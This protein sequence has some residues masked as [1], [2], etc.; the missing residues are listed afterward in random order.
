MRKPRGATP[1]NE[2]RLLAAAL[3]VIILFWLAVSY[4]HGVLSPEGRG[5]LNDLLHPEP[6]TLALRIMIAALIGL[7]AWYTQTMFDRYAATV[8][9]LEHERSKL[10]MV[11]DHSPDAVIILDPDYTVRY[12]N[13][14][15]Q[16][17]TR[18]DPE[19]L[20]GRRCFEAVLGLDGPCEGCRLDEVV[21]THAPQTGV[22]HS[23]DSTRGEIWIE[24]TF[25]PVLSQDGSIESVVE[26]ARD[27]T[28][29]RRAEVALQEYSE[30]LERE[31]HERTADI[32]RANELLTEEVAVR[33][34]AERAL[35]ESEERFR[36]LV[37]M[38]PDLILVHIEGVVSF[39]NPNGARMLGY[40]DPR[41]VLGTHV[42]EF[43]DPAFRDR[44]AEAL[45]TTVVERRPLLPTEFR[46]LRK[47]GTTVDV[48][49]SSTPLMYHGR[50]AVQAVAHD[51]TERKR[52]EET[53]RKMAYYDL[54][55][56]LP[57]R[58][59]F[60]DR[61]AV[62]IARAEREDSCFA[63]MFMDINDF[64]LINDSLGHA[65][66]DALLAE[67]G[68][69]LSKVVRRSDTVARLGGDEFTVL[70]P[71]VTSRKAAGLIAR[72]IVKALEEPMLIE[73]GAVPID[74]S[75]GI[76]FYPTDGRSFS[77]LMHAADMAMYASKNEDV[78]F[79]FADPSLVMPGKDASRA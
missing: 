72:K 3:G 58:A 36:S 13:P 49:V 59:L 5:F 17:L 42:L 38:A 8:R 76:A 15:T 45:R 62:A 40:D 2:P 20:V 53:I 48:Q 79:A 73:E 54:L 35:R 61:L 75:I 46:F 56:G 74:V 28:D 19:D 25:Y 33:R 10:Q 31:V 7:G 70:L 47:D 51:I 39:I 44:A 27:I 14:A 68:R 18:L 66:G 50:P 1:R 12:A 26:T 71:Q 32:E 55:T 16:R 64:K 57:N 78:P 23:V 43:V 4:V 29:I 37:E 41:D 69:R 67:I 63:V 6:P 60:D 65:V 9:T 52:A 22:K 21:R 11:Y 77:D 34:R 24:S 30:R